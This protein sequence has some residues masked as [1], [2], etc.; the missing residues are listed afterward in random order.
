M[1]PDR[2]PAAGSDVSVK[3]WR[4]LTGAEMAP[5]Y[6]LERLQWQRCFGWD[7]QANWAV[8]E[9]ARLTG[10]LPGLVAYESEYPVGWA[11]Y[12]V[13]RA[14]LQIGALTTLSPS[15]TRG[16]LDTI[17]DSPEAQMADSVM[18]FLPASTPALEAVLEDNGFDRQSFHY[19]TRD[20]NRSTGRQTTRSGLEVGRLEEVA[21]LLARAYPGA[22]RGRPFAQTGT[23]GEWFEYVERLLSGSGCGRWLPACSV[24]EEADDAQGL[25]RGV[26]LTTCLGPTTAH[27]VQVAVDPD[28]QGR[29]TGQTM[30]EDAMA[31]TAAAGYDR[32]TLLVA[33]RNHPA[34]RLYRRLGFRDSGAFVFA[35]RLQPRRSTSAACSTGGVSTLR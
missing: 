20:L 31:R 3:D 19:L 4:R 18:T 10:A 24:V 7:T 12:L 14:A 21:R 16:V 33:E 17:L 11:F 6:E 29:G 22:D 1:L 23:P 2:A 35:T 5:W 34:R 15:A 32:V 8:V 28:C 30:V 27:I 26:V 13:H 25:I 9:S